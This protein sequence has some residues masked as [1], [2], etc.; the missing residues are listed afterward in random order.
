M[1]RNIIAV[2]KDT[3]EV[4]DKVP[5]YCPQKTY[6]SFSKTGYSVFSHVALERISESDLEG[7][8]LRVLLRLIST[9]SDGNTI[10]VNQ[11]ELAKVMGIQKSHFSRSVK[12]LIE[13][14]ILVENIHKIG[15]CKTYQLN[16][17]YAWRGSNEAHQ[18]AINNYSQHERL[19]RLSKTIGA[20]TVIENDDVIVT[21]TAT[22]QPKVSKGNSQN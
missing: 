10:A 3:G 6:N 8:T 13:K 14:E 4:L 19:S 2:D 18:E 1:Y 17:N 5:V 16:P 12:I 15:R 9:I 11:S 21:I 7:V 20:D 22:I